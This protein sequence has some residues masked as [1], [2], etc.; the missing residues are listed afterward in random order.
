M[1]GEFKC[2][3]PLKKITW[4]EAKEINRIRNSY[5]PEDCADS[6][7]QTPIIDFLLESFVNY[8]KL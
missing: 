8:E 2:S 7:E 5:S 1:D 3:L 4:K 6:V